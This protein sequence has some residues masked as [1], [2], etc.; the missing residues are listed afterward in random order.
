MDQLAEMVNWRPRLEK[1]F[2]LPNDSRGSKNKVYFF[3]I[4][5]QLGGK[6][7]K[8]CLAFGSCIMVQ[9]TTMESALKQAREGIA[10]TIELAYEW[11]RES[12]A[13]LVTSPLEAG[14][15]TQVGGARTH[16]A[17]PHAPNLATDEKLKAMILHKLGGKKWS[18]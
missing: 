9:A 13:A 4:D 7:F 5:G 14:L 16:G 6:Q 1:D 18:W 10:A 12:Q 8:G 11:W 17:L 2:R 15:E 3:S